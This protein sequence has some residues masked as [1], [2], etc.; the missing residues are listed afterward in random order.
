MGA[1]CA[2][3]ACTLPPVPIGPAAALIFPPIV[4]FPPIENALTASSVFRTTTKS[5]ISAP[6]CNPQPK[7]PV[8]MHEGADHE[9]SGKRAMTRPDPALPENT[10]PALRTWKTARP[11]IRSMS[12][13]VH[14]AHS[15]SLGRGLTSGPLQDC[16]GYRIESRFRVCWIGYRLKFSNG[17]KVYSA[18]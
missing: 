1:G 12:H 8:A 5:V 17:P 7:P 15:N 18:E 14:I 3:E 11:E 9:P 4:T 2:N 16:L 13:D 6:I 10:N